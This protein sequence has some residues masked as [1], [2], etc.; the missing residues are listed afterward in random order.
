[1]L[2]R[3]VLVVCLL[4]I[5]LVPVGASQNID[6]AI[7]GDGLL[8]TTSEYASRV[9]VYDSSGKCVRRWGSTFEDGSPLAFPDSI[10][11]DL[12]SQVHVSDLSRRVRRFTR[13]GKSLLTLADRPENQAGVCDIA[14]DCHGGVYVLPNESS[15][16]I[17]YTSLGK[18]DRLIRVAGSVRNDTEPT[19]IAVD[20][21]S[22]V[23]A[24]YRTGSVL[25]YSSS[26]KK[27]AC[28]TPRDE[29]G[30]KL[31]LVDITVS[32]SGGIYVLGTHGAWRLGKTGKIESGVDYWI[33][34]ENPDFTC[35]YPPESIAVD[36]HGY[37]YIGF[38]HS[39]TPPEIR[40]YDRSWKLVRKWAILR[41]S[42]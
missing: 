30:N 3:I 40:K 18:V 25:K 21:K 19:A 10:A 7:A 32:R 4:C 22:G 14:T 5:G 33:P 34:G 37:V 24:V 31:V 26:G 12:Q 8:Y 41:G 42:R 35:P 16:V 15:T 9:Q 20:L 17:R 36:R 11:V 28:W 29:D 6:L 23:Y 2:S 1:M 38:D 39:N 27:I 13:F